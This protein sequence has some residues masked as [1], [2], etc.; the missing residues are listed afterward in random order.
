ME[1]VEKVRRFE[2]CTSVTYTFLEVPIR[3]YRGD[4]HATVWINLLGTGNAKGYREPSSISV[5]VAISCVAS[6]R[7]NEVN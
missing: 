2:L 3:R 4:K 7:S 1:K 6:F 5:K